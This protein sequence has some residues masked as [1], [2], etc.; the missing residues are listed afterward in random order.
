M[1]TIRF[2]TWVAVGALAVIEAFGL[3][4]GRFEL[5]MG[6]QIG[7]DVLIALQ[8]GLLCVYCYYYDNK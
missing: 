1:K 8:A 6:R 7:S 3:A 2:W 4:A 5:S